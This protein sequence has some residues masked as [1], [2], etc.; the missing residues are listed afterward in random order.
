MINNISDI[1]YNDLLEQ[2]VLI[3]EQLLALADFDKRS[4][5][6]ENIKTQLADPNIWTDQDQIKL[7]SKEKSQ[8]ET[9]LFAI[10]QFANNLKDTQ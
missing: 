6:L 4:A 1:N 2:L 9:A 7:L 8:L 10:N 5:T 3:K